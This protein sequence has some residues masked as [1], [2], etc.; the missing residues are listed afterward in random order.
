MTRF[1]FH[2]NLEQGEEQAQ[3]L[4]QF[5]SLPNRPIPHACCCVGPRDGDP[6]C[7]CRMAYVQIVNGKYYEISEI[8][9]SGIVEYKINEVVSDVE[10]CEI[11]M[12]RVDERG[13]SLT[14]ARKKR[15]NYLKEKNNAPST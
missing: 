9:G 3:A 14:E 6:V 11:H 5:L 10:A 12:P 7:P 1:K 4:H 15:L 8:P 2:I 13:M